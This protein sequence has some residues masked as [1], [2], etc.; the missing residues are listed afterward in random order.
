MGLVIGQKKRLGRRKENN[1]LSLKK[2][3]SDLKKIILN[4]N[5][6]KIV[7]VAFFYFLPFWRVLS[8]LSLCRFSHFYRF[9]SKISKT[10]LILPLLGIVSI[11]SGYN[12]YRSVMET[13]KILI[14]ANGGWHLTRETMVTAPYRIESFEKIAREIG[15]IG[16]VVWFRIIKKYRLGVEHS[17]RIREPFPRLNQTT[18]RPLPDNFPS[19]LG[20]VLLKLECRN[21]KI[22]L[23]RVIFNTIPNRAKWELV[24]GLEEGKCSGIYS[25]EVT[26]LTPYF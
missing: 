19:N 10:G 2:V 11:L 14:D 15:E 18:P 8:I 6:K 9:L 12:S 5:L 16:G 25:V 4:S 21:G 1:F 23:Q 22:K 17:I 3:N 13:P 26:F 24:K 7:K 20:R